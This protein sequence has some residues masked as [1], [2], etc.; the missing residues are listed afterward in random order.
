MRPRRIAFVLFVMGAAACGARTALPV[1]GQPDAGGTDAAPDRRDAGRDALS[2]DV[3]IPPIDANKPDVPTPIDCP[4]ASET[5]IYLLGSQN[6]LYSFSPPTLAFKKLGTL[7]CAAM[8]G[9]PFSMAVNRK[10]TAYVVYTNGR[11]FQ[12]STGTLACVPTSF[13]PGQ[14][15][16]Q[17]FG[18]GFA[19]DQNGD[20]L[21]VSQTGTPSIGLATIDTMTF[22]LGFIAAFTPSI[23]RNELAGTGDGRLFAYWPNVDGTA[24][25]SLAQIDRTT[26]AV[27]GLNKLPVGSQ[28]DAFAFAYWGGLFW[29]FTGS[30][31]TTVSTYDLGTQQTKTVT[32]AP[33]LIVGAGVSTCAPQ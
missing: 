25:G 7:T 17:T 11:L 15:G 28:S 24:G 9:T 22:G 33:A 16:F 23:P 19:A 6:E 20:K 10:G 2:E 29:I 26:A 14:M 3:F 27:K 5:L 8:G 1:D 31:T 18:M 32:T 21:Y 12:V 30:S 13:V 4:D